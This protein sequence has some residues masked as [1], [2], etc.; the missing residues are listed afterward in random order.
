[1]PA[2]AV[3][4]SKGAPAGTPLYFSPEV[5]AMQPAD[6][7]SDLWALALVLYEAIAG[8]NPMASDSVIETV[9]RI[10]GAVVPDLRQCPARV[11][12]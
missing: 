1:M 2:S 6:R 4:D 9:E 8:R 5:L 10:R 11:P 12:A 3:L 7:L